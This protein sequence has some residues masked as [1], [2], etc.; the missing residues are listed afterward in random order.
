MQKVELGKLEN[1]SYA[2]K[3]SFNSLRTNLSFCGPDIKTIVFTSCTPNE[4][5]SS[6]VIGLA[7]AVAEDH[8]KVLVVD[9]D[10]RKSP[11]IGRHQ[12]SA[13]EN[14][15]KGMS[16]YLTGQAEME[17]IIYETNIENFHIAF[18]GRTTPSPTE[19]LG[20]NLFKEFMAKAREEYDLILI[21]SPP[22]GSVIDTA[23]IAPV[24]DGAILLVESN[25]N[26]YK[27]LQE[28][29]KQLDITGVRIL[30]VVLNKVQPHDGGYYK[31]YYSKYYA[32]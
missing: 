10:L 7:R 31:N 26:S 19:L 30:G 16:H 23:V 28:V 14:E 13:G 22:I 20:S 17:E 11:L 15:I 29:K 9:C 21:D 12:V 2:K 4:G 24:C 1:Q 27:Y 5:K 6:T 18:A 32:Q 3:E 8:K 25:K